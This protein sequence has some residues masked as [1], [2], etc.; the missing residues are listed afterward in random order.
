[1][2]MKELVAKIKMMASLDPSVSHT[3]SKTEK[4]MGEM[5][6]R[7]KKIKSSS[8]IPGNLNES[9]SRLSKLGDGLSSVGKKMQ[10][11]G[12]VTQ[13][14]GKLM[15]PVSGAAAA[16][17]TAS[18]KMAN[19]YDNAMAK[20]NTI[21][22]LSSSKLKGL[23]GG[24]LKVSNDTG[25]S[26]TEIAEA[27]YQSLSASVPTNQVA[28]FTKVAA[29]LAKTGFTDTASSVD[30]LSTAINAYGLKTSQ[31]SKL[32]DMLIQTQNRGKTTVNELASQMGNVIPTASAL[33]VNMANLST[34]YVQLTKQGIN[35]A[36]ATTQLRAIFNEL[37]KSGTTVDK[38]LRKQT[39][40]SFT[41][42]M[43]SGKSLGDIMGILSK[44]VKGNKTEFKNLWSNTRAGSG[45]LALLNAGVGD[46]DSQ[47]KDMNN[48]TGNTA[49]ALK[50]LQTPGALAKKSINQ[51]KNSGI[52]LGETFL[53][54]ASPAIISIAKDISK[55][56][57]EFNKLDP[58]TKKMIGKAAVITAAASPALIITGKI[59]SGVGKMVATIG[60]GI[61]KVAQ[62]AEKMKALKDAGSAAGSEIST[63]GTSAESTASNVGALTT[64]IS[65][66]AVALGVAAAAVVGLSAVMLSQRHNFQASSSEID[67]LTKKYD[68]AASKTGSL[69]SSTE[70][71]IK[72]SRESNSALA[73]NGKVAE[74]LASKI[75]SLSS[76]ENKSAA[77]KQKL[78]AEV[79]ALNSVVPGLNLSYNAEKDTL[80]Q[81]NG[82]IEKNI[83]LL[84]QQ[85]I[86]KQAAKNASGLNVK[87]GKLMIQQS[88]NDVNIENQSAKVDAIRK[89]YYAALSKFNKLQANPNANAG[90]VAKARQEVSKYNSM[91]NKGQKSL[92]AYK[93][94]QSQLNKELG[95]VGKEINLNGFTSAL[96]EAKQAGKKVPTSLAAGMKSTM[97]VLPSTT[98]ELTNAI[99]YKTVIN[100]AKDAGV[101]IPTALS[102]K[103][104]TGKV[105]VKKAESQLNSVIKFDGAV[106]KAKK[107]GVKIP[108]NLS[109]GVDSGKI[110]A[111]QASDR[112]AQVVK[113]DKAVKKAKKQ[114]S[115]TA[116][117]LAA[118]IASGKMTVQQAS[119]KL[120]N[121]SVSKLD[122]SKD[123]KSK[124]LKTNKSFSN[125]VGQ[126]SAPS[127]AGRSAANAGVAPFKKVPGRVGSALSGLG[128]KIRNAFTFKVPHIPIPHP[129]ITGHFDLKKGTVPKFSMN[130]Y[131]NGGIMTKPTVFG[132]NG[133]HL[134]AGGEA[135]PE[136]II[137]LR[138]LWENL[139]KSI[140]GSVTSNVQNI[141]TENGDAVNSI[142]NLVNSKAVNTSNNTAND[143]SKNSVFRLATDLINN[144]VK[145][146]VSGNNNSRNITRYFASSPERTSNVE[147]TIIRNENSLLNRA[148]NTNTSVGNSQEA[149]YFSSIIKNGSLE[150]I[151]N[152]DS[153]TSEVIRGNALAGR[154]KTS[155]SGDKSINISGITF[156]PNIVIK[157]NASKKDIIAALK[158]SEDEFT[159]YLK[160]I[161]RD[162]EDASY[163]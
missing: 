140:S 89:K 153:R 90:D 36:A 45:A 101:K 104:V 98:Q 72:K 122:K 159:D 44:S 14:V 118:S 6:A 49:A 22:G 31:A 73:S 146:A 28:K 77:Q 76:V 63:L 154:T 8:V 91:L 81:T 66:G 17:I 143:N 21:A 46:F 61:G 64:G 38:T 102:Q 125:G 86:A 132:A 139:D 100:K 47:L 110:T 116:K 35:T 131:K 124:G 92:D 85:S 126:T 93:K 134:L 97:K 123:A 138:K 18:I 156:A 107:Q 87:R 137:P 12:S 53:D 142:K 37:S 10:S 56:T 120:G 99:K 103:I 106:K 57:N 59:T 30:V 42:L 80:S 52:E 23:S 24:L 20:V 129:G 69:I 41:D 78:K 19:D 150:N 70:S 155:K 147:K 161:L 68:S 111:K 160:Q 75:R 51:L 83:A 121:A 71:Q 29:N 133:S 7:A 58:A 128:T 11:I 145:N 144:Y 50:K 149:Q 96:A 108:K 40:K 13:H 43:K 105:T 119:A 60:E 94:K 152:S 3:F 1:M 95:K 2:A 27:A 84:K 65:A 136:G 16:G 130:W 158:E 88:A 115:K 54:A 117:N 148:V 135:G 55:L 163:A 25:K 62:F 141:Y 157:G 26:A 151:Y 114:G 32:S 15:A 4:M 127:S 39:G 48:S 34:G 9:Q 5:E 162:E 74:S 82:Q 79:S 113:F 109:S 33:N 112:L 67:K